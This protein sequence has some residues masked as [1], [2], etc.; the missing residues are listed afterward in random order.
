MLDNQPD[1]R[2]IAKLMAENSPS[3][4]PIIIKK[5]ANRRLYNTETSSYIT[6]ENLAQMV[7]Q[8]REFLRRMVERIEPCLVGKRAVAAEGQP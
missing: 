5:Y 8:N 2:R 4:A 1:P 3:K 7:R 6:L